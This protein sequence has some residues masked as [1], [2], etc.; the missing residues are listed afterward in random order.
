MGHLSFAFKSADANAIKFEAMVHRFGQGH[1]RTAF[2]RALTHEGRK[3]S[4]AV[5]RSL[6][7]ETSI[8]T[9]HISKAV[10]FLAASP[11][12][13]RAV[14]VAK[15]RHL[16]L[17]HF[18]PRQIKAGVSAVVW[19]RRQRF[20]GAFVLASVARGGAFVRTDNFNQKSK[21][22]NAIRTMF[23]PNA[24]KEMVE[25]KTAAVFDRASDGLAARAMHELNRILNA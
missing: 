21:R 10:K 8:K 17:R 14:T 1:G 4:T 15:D 2:A 16:E 6:R 23:G 24:A 11:K 9:S 25:D 5:K 13:L 19:G 20:K 18:G 12:N 7:T 22:F 3:A